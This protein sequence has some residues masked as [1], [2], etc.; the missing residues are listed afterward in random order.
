LLLFVVWRKIFASRLMV[1]YN[2]LLKTWCGTS[3]WTS[4]LSCC[5]YLREQ[6][7]LQIPGLSIL[8]RQSCLCIGGTGGGHTKI[9][10]HHG[11]ILLVVGGV[12]ADL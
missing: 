5:I 7:L 8:C 3:V 1:S 10:R 4:G 2:L 9:R 11:P 6:K 12:K